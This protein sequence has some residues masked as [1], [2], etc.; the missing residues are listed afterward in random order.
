MKTQV[1]GFQCNELMLDRIDRLA[2]E[3]LKLRPELSSSTRSDVIRVA[4]AI[5][6]SKLEEQSYDL[7]MDRGEV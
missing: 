2:A 1:V 7:K 3:L 5:G 4:I 6:L